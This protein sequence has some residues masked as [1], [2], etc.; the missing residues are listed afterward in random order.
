MKQF[1]ARLIG[2][3]WVMTILTSSCLAVD[4]KEVFV[5]GAKGSDNAL[6]TKAAPLQT[7]HAVLTRLP[8]QIDHDVL[9]HMHGEIPTRRGAEPS[10]LELNRPMREGVKVRII[11]DASTALLNWTA[12]EQPLI[13]ATQGR[14]SLENLQ[15]GSRL[16]GQSQGVL[17][18]GPATV[19]MHS[20][21]IRTASGNSPGIHSTRGGLVELYGKIELNEDLHEKN[22]A[23]QNFCGILASYGG[24][25]RFRERENAALSIGNGSL[26]SVYYG[27]IELGCATA[28]ITSWH[29][30]ANVIAVNDSGRVDFHSTTATLAARN[31]RNTPIGLEDDGHVLAEGARITIQGFDN[32]NAIVLQKASSFFCNDVKFDG[33]FHSP[34]LAMSGSTLLV[35]VIGDLNGGEVTTGARIILEKCTGKVIRPISESNQGVLIVA[36]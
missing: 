26:S 28:R 8:P 29:D 18:T 3:A 15:I 24:V 25:V 2:A 14:W 16:N 11:G 21:R 10:T 6:G 35:G 17:T 34:V 12:S 33:P 19:E 4:V 5:D 1:P 23:G 20:V 7:L 36:K 30:Q 27:V 13:S 31:P 22:D 9:I 32:G